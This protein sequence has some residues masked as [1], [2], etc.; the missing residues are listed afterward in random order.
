MI[1]EENIIPLDLNNTEEQLGTLKQSGEINGPGNPQQQKSVEP[2][3][4]IGRHSRV[5]GQNSILNTFGKNFESCI[6][7]LEKRI[8]VPAD[9]KKTTVTEGQNV[10][11]RK[12]FLML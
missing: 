3:N 2:K 11:I 5:F 7:S 6:T 1:S 12:I 8:S 4:E 10:L 9:Q